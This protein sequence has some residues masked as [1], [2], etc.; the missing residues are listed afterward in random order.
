[1]C[2]FPLTPHGSLTAPTLRSPPEQIRRASI[3]LDTGAHTLQFSAKQVVQDRK[4]STETKIKHTLTVKIK[5]T[6]LTADH[7]PLRSTLKTS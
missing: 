4:S 5:Y 1:M 2:M 6:V 7:S 3:L